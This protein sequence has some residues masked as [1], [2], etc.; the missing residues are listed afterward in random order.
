MTKQESLDL[1]LKRVIP[2]IPGLTKE[3][4]KARQQISRRAALEQLKSIIGLSPEGE[5]A[6]QKEIE[7]DK[8]KNESP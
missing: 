7:K 5:R 8:K 2:D 4:R 1:G 3:A 6:L